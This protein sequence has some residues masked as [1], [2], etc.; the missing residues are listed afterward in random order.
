MNRSGPR[1]LAVTARGGRGA[2]RGS[3]EGLTRGEGVAWR[4][5]DGGEGAAALGAGGARV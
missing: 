2:R 5:D 4:P 1:Q 3:V